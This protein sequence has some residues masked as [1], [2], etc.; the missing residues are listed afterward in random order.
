MCTVL[1]PPGDNPFV[2]NKYII[3]YQMTK[4][5][6]NVEKN[7]TFGWFPGVWFIY[8]DVSKHSICSIFK[9]T[10]LWRWNRQSVP[11]RR[12][13]QIRRRGITQK[14]T[15][16][17]LNTAKA[18]NHEGKEFATFRCDAVQSGRS[19]PTFQGDSAAFIIRVG[20]C[21]S[22]TQRLVKFFFWEQAVII[23]RS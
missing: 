15:N 19:L 2:V 14:K 21:I 3:S 17:I 10:C 13:K 18:W 20:P 23:L 16:N 22:T 4:N 1:L 5:G 6:L 11:K 8:A 7:Y 9:G 12:H